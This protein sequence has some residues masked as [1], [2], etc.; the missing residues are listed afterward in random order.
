MITFTNY[1]RSI[2]KSMINIINNMIMSI[3]DGRLK[4]KPEELRKGK[5]EKISKMF[6]TKMKNVGSKR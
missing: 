1:T 3:T 6:V 4:D 5:I 2:S